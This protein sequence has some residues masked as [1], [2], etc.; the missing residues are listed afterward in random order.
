MD[1]IPASYDGEI[2]ELGAG[3]GALTLG[4]ATKCPNARI[5]ACEINP[6]L[7]QVTRTN[8]DMAGLS[9]RV[10]VLSSPAEHLLESRAE[11]PARRVN[12][13]L[14]GIPLCNLNREHVQRLLAA[15]SGALKPGG[16][17]IQFQHSLIDRKK[18]RDSFWRLRTVPVILNLPPA[19]V[20][21][22]QK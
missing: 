21:F 19:F 15:V 10:Q 16:W 14:S 5:T 2:I 22:A 3:T 18:I 9:D 12:F 20:Y 17:Y 8:L 1:P 7:A 6:M 4:L 13:V 11:D